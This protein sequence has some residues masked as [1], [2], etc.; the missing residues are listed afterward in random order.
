M[1]KRKQLYLCLWLILFLPVV[2]LRGAESGQRPQPADSYQQFRLEADLERVKDRIRDLRARRNRELGDY[3]RYLDKLDELEEQ[4]DAM[5]PGFLETIL[6]CRADVYETTRHPAEARDAYQRLVDEFPDSPR[7]NYRRGRVAYLDE[8][9]SKYAELAARPKLSTSERVARRMDRRIE[10]NDPYPDIPESG[11]LGFLSY[12]SEVMGRVRERLTSGELDPAAYA[13]DFDLLEEVYI[14]SDVADAALRFQLLSMQATIAWR[15][16]QDV[17]EAVAILKR[18]EG[19]MAGTE[20]AGRIDQL[21]AR[22]QGKNLPRAGQLFPDFTFT[23]MLG[24]RISLSDYRGKVVLIDFWAT[25]CPP[26]I[27]ELPNLRRAYRDFHGKGFEIIG[28]SLDTDRDRLLR[29]LD[30]EQMLWPQ[31]FDGQ[32][33]DNEISRHFNIRSIPATFLVGPDGRII[34]TDLRGDE[35]EQALEEALSLE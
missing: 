22:I 31:F 24:Q 35:L 3:Q 5:P 27:R 4:A 6:D 16:Q 21:I 19:E 34:A 15:I 30:Q 9:A 29:F 25:W 17:N 18:M 33:W 1:R 32:G 26:C 7:L 14:R 8:K 12:A 23:S 28:I 13:G 10:E 2:V 11:S 20:M